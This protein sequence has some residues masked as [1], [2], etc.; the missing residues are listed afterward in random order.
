MD[1][2]QVIDIVQRFF[3]TMMS[4]KSATDL[5]TI[6][7]VEGFNAIGVDATKRSVQV[8]M[9]LLK[10]E[11][12]TSYTIDEEGT[13]AERDAYDAKPKGFSYLDTQTK[14]IYRK[15]SNASGD[16]GEGI[17]FTADLAL[18]AKKTELS[19]ITTSEYSSKIYPDI[20]I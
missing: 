19:N 12:G 17:S 11:A 9:S 20:T 13:T 8:P 6:S 5:P 3:D 14:M 2:Q 1:E 16:W 4:K 18:Y 7:T 10:G 15:K